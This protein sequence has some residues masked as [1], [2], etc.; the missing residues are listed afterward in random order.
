[1]TIE[2]SQ[3]QALYVMLRDSLG[4]S[5]HLG[6]P[7]RN[8]DLGEQITFHAHNDSVSRVSPHP[9]ADSGLEI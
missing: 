2:D 5:Q 6:N 4:K 3:L 1:M 9:P 8:G 7:F